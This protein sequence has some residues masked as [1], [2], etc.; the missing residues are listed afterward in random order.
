MLASIC[1]IKLEIIS[2]ACG[3]KETQ[4]RGGQVNHL[5]VASPINWQ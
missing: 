3:E 4:E 5:R 2:V 1:V